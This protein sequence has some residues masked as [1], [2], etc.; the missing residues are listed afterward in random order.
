MSRSHAATSGFSGHHCAIADIRY[1]ACDER[2]EDGVLVYLK[3]SLSG[4]EPAGVHHYAAQNAGFPNGPR[5]IS[6]STNPS[7]RATAAQATMS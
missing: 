2:A 5:R 6:S 1:S 3:P 7:S 4:D